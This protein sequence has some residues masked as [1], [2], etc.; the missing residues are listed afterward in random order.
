MESPRTMAGHVLSNKNCHIVMIVTCSA[1]TRK[2]FIWCVFT[3]FSKMSAGCFIL[4]DY[5][6]AVQKICNSTRV[7]I[8]LYVYA[9]PLTL[10]VGT[11]FPIYPQGWRQEF[12]DRGLTL[13]MRG[14]KYCF[15]GIV[16]AKNLRQNSFHLP[17]GH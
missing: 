2:S 12:S 4:L 9:I 13:P 11:H 6:K 14:L 1:T 5:M 10:V 3:F 15:Q 17:T 8:H 16:N 7:Q